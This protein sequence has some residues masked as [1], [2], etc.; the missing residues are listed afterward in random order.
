VLNS[1][2]FYKIIKL[3]KILST[4]KN[5]KIKISHVLI[6]LIFLFTNTSMVGFFGIDVW[7]VKLTR[8]NL[9]FPVINILELS[10]FEFLTQVWFVGP[11]FYLGLGCSFNFNANSLVP[12]EKLKKT[13]TGYIYKWITF[14][15]L[16]VAIRKSF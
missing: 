4:I 12:H 3:K 7:S 13:F 15:L 14:V 9:F 6:W 2:I 16:M 11:N 8:V 5:K 10:W 1:I